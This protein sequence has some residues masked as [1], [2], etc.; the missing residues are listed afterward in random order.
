MFSHIWEEIS[1]V[2]G[3]SKCM[4]SL[5]KLKSLG[6]MTEAEGRRKDDLV[7]PAMSSEEQFLTSRKF[8]YFLDNEV[9]MG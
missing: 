2:C 8:A 9:A 3:Y 6:H 1:P 5:K 7:G 4:Y